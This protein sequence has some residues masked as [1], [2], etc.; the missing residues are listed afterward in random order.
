[1][2]QTMTHQRTHDRAPRRRHITPRVD[3][4]ETSRAVVLVADIPGVAQDDLDIR[5]D[6]DV[7]TIRGQVGAGADAAHQPEMFRKF[8][9]SDQIDRD[10]IEAE[11]K[12]GVLRLTL[13]KAE[14]AKTRKIDVNVG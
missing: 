2:T 4:V 7:L 8:K 12:H 10:H 11:L 9:L 13:P 6:Q 14:T 1:M 3:V 5:L